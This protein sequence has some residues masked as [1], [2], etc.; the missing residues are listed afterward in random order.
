MNLIELLRDFGWLFFCIGMV[1]QEKERNRSRVESKCS[2]YNSATE[3]SKNTGFHDVV[4][5]LY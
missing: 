4:P 5:I 2:V 1:Q 3:P